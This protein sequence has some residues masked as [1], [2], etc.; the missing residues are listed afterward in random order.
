MSQGNSRVFFQTRCS[1]M[2]T[3]QALR[4]CLMFALRRLPRVFRRSASWA[5]V[6]C[7]ILNPRDVHAKK[8]KQTWLMPRSHQRLNM[9]KSCLVEL[10]LLCD[11]FVG[12]PLQMSPVSFAALRKKDSIFSIGYPL[13]VSFSFFSCSASN[14]LVLCYD[15]EV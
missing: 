14:L 2:Q 13:T 15:P 10:M 7:E 5:L 6:W 8:Y 4:N 12:F 3:G 1:T 9:F 11:R